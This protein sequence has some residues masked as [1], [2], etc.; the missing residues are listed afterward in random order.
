MEQAVVPRLKVV[1]HSRECRE[2]PL[3]I[4]DGRVQFGVGSDLHERLQ[5]ERGRAVALLRA[6]AKVL[7]A[8]Q[9]LVGL[10]VVPDVPD[11]LHDLGERLGPRHDGA[12]LPP[13]DAA[14]DAVALQDERTVAD[15]VT[16]GVE[17]S[18]RQGAAQLVGVAARAEVFGEVR[19]LEDLLERQGAVPEPLDEVRERLA[20]PL[21]QR[22]SLARTEGDGRAR[23][24]AQRSPAEGTGA[25]LELEQGRAEVGQ[26]AEPRL[27]PRE[28]GRGHGLRL[29]RIVQVE[30]GELREPLG[31]RRPLDPQEPRQCFHLPLEWRELPV[32]DPERAHDAV[33]RLVRE[34]LDVGD[35]LHPG[36]AREVAVLAEEPLQ[37]ADPPGERELAYPH[38]PERVAEVANHLVLAGQRPGGRR[39]RRGGRCR[40]GPN[41]PRGHATHGHL[42]VAG[43]ALLGPLVPLGLLLREDLA[44]GR[45]LLD[46]Q[47]GLDLGDALLK[48][49]EPRR[50]REWLGDLGLEAGDLR[51]LL[52][53]D[54]PHRHERRVQPAQDRVGAG[55]GWDAHRVTPATS[56]R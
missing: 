25:R 26:G 24:L 28:E 12:I 33:P 56:E 34:G 52:R 11:R 47:R 36:V 54:G 19:L 37:L 14:T 10:V 48:R 55:D 38:A 46:S 49:R 39:R 22:E 32:A 44:D 2:V 21:S 13:D 6:V 18:G 35:L 42:E 4:P 41:E 7:D 5:V 30:P 53:E 45:A 31:H 27:E 23:P 20:P 16:E 51:L 43:P 17:L 1:E 3:V 40:G 9:H 29:G 15:E 50:L 8:P